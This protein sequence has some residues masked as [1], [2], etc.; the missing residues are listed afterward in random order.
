MTNNQTT[1]HEGTTL[2]VE[3]WLP[4]KE[5]SAEAQCCDATIKRAIKS[6]KLVGRKVG[7][8]HTA[9]YEVDKASF[10]EWLAT[11]G[12]LKRQDQPHSQQPRKDSPATESQATT[13]SAVA[14]TD[15]TVDGSE[16]K[17]KLS[18]AERRRLK[19]ERKKLI[20]ESA[21]RLRR[22]K[23]FMRHA[24]QQQALA[25][26]RWLSARIKTG[27]KTRNGPLNMQVKAARCRKAKPSKRHR[28]QD[29]TTKNNNPS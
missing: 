28:H 7:E 3:I 24:D 20:P 14:N 10:A 2:E 21:R 16:T 5:A 29:E 13:P 27:E 15:E 6:G 17:P 22:W 8:S 25:M 1:E 12:K 23:N 26:I 18:K 11:N 19:A 4:L 9:S